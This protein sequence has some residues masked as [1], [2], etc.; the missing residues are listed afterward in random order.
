[1]MIW[2]VLDQNGL[3][4]TLSVQFSVAMT[5]VTAAGPAAA[6]SLATRSRTSYALE[7]AP[8]ACVCAPRPRTEALRPGVAPDVRITCTTCAARPRTDTGVV[9]SIAPRADE[10]V[11]DP[12]MNPIG[13]TTV[14]D[15]VIVARALCAAAGAAVAR[16]SATAAANARAALLMGHRAQ[17]RAAPWVHLL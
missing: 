10:T 16:I 17:A 13:S 7:V 9:T 15:A 4:G 8:F 14:A 11:L 2:S 3:A 5:Y 1:M 12:A 6:V